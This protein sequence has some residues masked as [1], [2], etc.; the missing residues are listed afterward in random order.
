LFT[1]FAGKN[2]FHKIIERPGQ[3]CVS[4]TVSK[5][6]EAKMLL[7]RIRPY[8]ELRDGASSITEIVNNTPLIPDLLVDTT[9]WFRLDPSSMSKFIAAKNQTREAK[10]KSI[11]SYLG[12]RVRLP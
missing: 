9:A 6:D 12:G 10:P 2:F 7:F 8:P 1:R 3:L 11:Q 5:A 4:G